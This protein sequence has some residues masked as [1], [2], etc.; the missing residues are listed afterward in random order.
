[1]Q[2]GARIV[3]ARAGPAPRFADIRIDAPA[4]LR[5]ELRRDRPAFDNVCRADRW[6]SRLMTDF[7]R[8][9]A[10][11]SSDPAS[12]AAVDRQTNLKVTGFFG[13][14]V[15]GCRSSVDAGPRWMPDVRRF[16]DL[17]GRRESEGRR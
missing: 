2:L 17:S 14:G 13:H 8:V 1:M 5:L 9:R 11:G 3:V 10:F 4:T 6:T 7:G 16:C 15:G 12:A